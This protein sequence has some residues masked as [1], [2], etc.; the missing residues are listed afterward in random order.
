[1]T[2]LTALV[3]DNLIR[4]I[5]SQMSRLVAVTTNRL[6]GT[7]TSNV[8]RLIAV[9]A[10]LLVRTI[11]SQVTLL[12]AVTANYSSSGSG[13]TTSIAARHSTPLHLPL[14]GTVRSNVPTLAAVEAHSS[15]IL[16]TL[17]R[18]ILSNMTKSTTIVTS[19]RSLV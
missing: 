9:A 18:T 3:A 8:S 14:F 5:G 2:R 12:V 13:T 4:A 19:L 16:C 17:A 10:H 11:T 6:I 1:M 15:L 7:V